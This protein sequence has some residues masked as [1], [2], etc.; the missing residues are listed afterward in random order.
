MRLLGA[1]LRLQGKQKIA[2]FLRSIPSTVSPQTPLPKKA[3]CVALLGSMMWDLS[4]MDYE[5]ETP[6]CKQTVQSVMRI[7][8]SA[9]NRKI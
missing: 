4:R 8:S 5:P 9:A 6:D 7:F 1:V 3:P 2:G